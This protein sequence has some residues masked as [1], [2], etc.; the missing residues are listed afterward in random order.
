MP[1]LT[2]GHKMVFNGHPSHGCNHISLGF[3]NISLITCSNN[4]RAITPSSIMGK[5]LD[6]VVLFKEHSA[7]SSSDIQFGFKEHVSTIQ[8]VI[9]EIIYYQN[10]SISNAY[11]VLLDVSTAFDKVNDCKHFKKHLDKDMP[12]L[13]LTLLAYL[14]TNQSL[15]LR[16]GQLCAY[17][18]GNKWENS[19]M[20]TYYH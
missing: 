15:Q 7:L 20:I 11:C 19:C 17:Y 4:Q 2:F 12:P 18:I 9:S 14:Y 8:I 1:L 3:V 10:V 6:Q 13:V 16:W 5:V